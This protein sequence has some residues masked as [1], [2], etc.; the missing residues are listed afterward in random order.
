[1]LAPNTPRVLAIELT[2]P[3][4]YQSPTFQFRTLDP[5]AKETRFAVWND[6]HE[7]QETI[8]GVH[9]LTTDFK[10]DFLLWNGDQTNDVYDPA[11]MSN[12]YLAPGGLAI[13]F[14]VPVPEAILLEGNAFVAV[15]DRVAA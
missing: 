11:K 2:P 13:A 4:T 9:R 8:A 15:D 5:S 10:P 14:S 7:N 3:K 1:M 12:Q 6:T